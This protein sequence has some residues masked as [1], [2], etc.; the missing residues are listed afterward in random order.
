MIFQSQSHIP[1]V[2][3]EIEETVLFISTLQRKNNRFICGAHE[4]ISLDTM[5]VKGNVL[6][7]LSSL[8]F[9]IER[10]SRQQHVND[11]LAIVCFSGLSGMMGMKKNLVCLQVALCVCKAGL[12]IYKLMNR[13]LLEVEGKDIG[14]MVFPS[15]RARKAA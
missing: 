7:N 8:R 13:S 6:Y 14:A 15:K 11:S 12:H 9:Y 3:V 2:Y 4:I 10:F 1:K 5:E